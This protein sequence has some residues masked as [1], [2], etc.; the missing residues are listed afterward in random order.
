[1]KFLELD[2]SNSIQNDTNEI[3][4]TVPT[5]EFKG[6]IL[7]DSSCKISSI[8]NTVITCDIFSISSPSVSITNIT[9][10][11]TV[12][13]EYSNNFSISHCV[14]KNAEQSYGALCIYNSKDV[15]INHVTI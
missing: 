4:I 1:M 15:T 9:F 11:S 3:T 14:I 8:C 2:S 6:E 13:V 12:S 10:Q 5:L 7:V